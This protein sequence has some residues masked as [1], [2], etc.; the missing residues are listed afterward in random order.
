MALS[1][2]S[3]TS[4]I[5]FIVETDRDVE[6]FMQSDD[7][8]FLRSV[9]TK[10]LRLPADAV[11]VLALGPGSDGPIAALLPDGVKSVVICGRELADR[12]GAQS[13]ELLASSEPA[14]IVTHS[15][16]SVR[17]DPAVK[18]EFWNCLQQGL[19]IGRS[20]GD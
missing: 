5:A 9:V 2:G 7:G 13:H 1:W 16:R 3:G 20:H 8:V 10:G 6:S 14:I 11:W 19:R 15:L 18:K 4:G 17:T 12:L